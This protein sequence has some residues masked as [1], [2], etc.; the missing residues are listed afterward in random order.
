[1]QEHETKST[2]YEIIWYVVIIMI[3]IMMLSLS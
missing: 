3:I 1:M 2:L